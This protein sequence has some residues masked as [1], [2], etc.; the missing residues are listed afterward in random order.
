MI[1]PDSKVCLVDFQ[2]TTQ[3]NSCIDPQQVV[4]VIDHH[5]LQNATIVVDLPIY[6]DIRLVQRMCGAERSDFSS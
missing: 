1:T 6:L 5:A 4:G 3:L 2:Q